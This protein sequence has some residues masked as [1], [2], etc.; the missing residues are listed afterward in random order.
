MINVSTNSVLNILLITH[1]LSVV[2]IFIVSSLPIRCLI[3]SYLLATKVTID[4]IN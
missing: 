1:D 3:R 4:S 2:I